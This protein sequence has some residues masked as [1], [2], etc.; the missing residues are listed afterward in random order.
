MAQDGLFG[1]L[2]FSDVILPLVGTAAASY[3]PYL[4]R[5]LQTGMGLFNSLANFQ[6]SAR[7]WQHLRSEREREDELTKTAQL[8][9]DPVIEEII[10]RQGARRGELEQGVRGEDIVRFTQAQGGL[11]DAISPEI[12]ERGVAGPP[13]LEQLTERAA[14][15]DDLSNAL[16]LYET[17]LGAYRAGLPL[18]PGAS[19]SGA[20]T[21]A[22]QLVGSDLD[23]RQIAETNK[24]WEEQA[25]RQLANDAINRSEHLKSVAEEVKIR[26]VADAEKRQRVIEQ[27]KQMAAVWDKALPDM[28]VQDLHQAIN[29]YVTNIAE[30]KKWALQGD[31]E[32]A[33]ALSTAVEQLE[34]L[35]AEMRTRTGTGGG[36]PNPANPQVPGSGRLD[37]AFFGPGEG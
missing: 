1:G 25:T 6:N 8:G 12:F 7:Y 19:I 33:V 10:R 32:A 28:D 29:R 3:S 27:T 30:L 36:N 14:S 37:N 18:S 15:G 21:L 4:A 5:G 2:R 16:R 17:Q 26:G 20:G 23:M 22:Q 11:P 13:N 31:P 35:R 34:V 9:M 24:L